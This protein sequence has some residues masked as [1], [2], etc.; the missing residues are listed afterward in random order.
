MQEI[1]NIGK[2]TGVNAN[3]VIVASDTPVAQNEICYIK[4]GDEKLIS[5]A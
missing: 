3:L 5:E 1:K 4:I 2:V